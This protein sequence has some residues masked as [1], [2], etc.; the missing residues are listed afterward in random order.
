MGEAKRKKERAKP[1]PEKAYM[2]IPLSDLVLYAVFSLET[3]KVETTFENI[4][5]E[6]FEL[7]PKKFSLHG[8]PEYPDANR[9]RREI[10]RLEGTLSSPGIEKLVDGN[11]K[12]SYRITEKGLKN[13]RKYKCV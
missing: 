7:F 13:S 1:F 8:Y 10:Q 9:V 12:T 3:K 4:V 6:C 5:A 11:M 2:D